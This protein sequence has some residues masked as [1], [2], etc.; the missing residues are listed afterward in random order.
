[1]LVV[2]AS[3]LMLFWLRDYWLLQL[4][5][6][7]GIRR[8]FGV[9]AFIVVMAA[10]SVCQITRHENARGVLIT[11]ESPPFLVA[12]FVLH[13]AAAVGSSWIRQKNHYQKAWLISM[14]PAPAAW[15]LLAQVMIL[16]DVDLGAAVKPWIV[17]IAGAAWIIIMA[18]CIWR[19][20]CNG[21]VF[22]E[23]D[24]AVEFSCWINWFGAGLVVFVLSPVA[25]DSFREAMRGLQR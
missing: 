22:K 11:I 13:A 21:S 24:Y 7:E 6:P 14:I 23:I 8:R 25:A 19:T 20:Q 16:P 1:M 2:T 18:F 12:L 9:Y 17:A 4:G 5:P 15:V 10:I 3:A